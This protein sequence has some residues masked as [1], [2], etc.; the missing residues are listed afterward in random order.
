MG[1]DGAASAVEQAS[2]T[3]TARPALKLTDT[4]WVASSED[5]ARRVA[6]ELAVNIP[7]PKGGNFNGVYWENAVGMPRGQIESVLQYNAMCQWVRALADGRQ[8]D[9]AR[10][11]LGVVPQWPNFGEPS[12][13]RA[14]VIGL[15]GNGPM[16]WDRV[17]EC[18]NSATLEA[19]H[20]RE[21]GLL[22]SV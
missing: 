9:S 4:S 16:Y 2:T 10:R 8:A 1:H 19:A 18:R 22:P 3:L 21:A 17:E 5:E 15:A 7:V 13:T 11:I 20:A 6:A 12:E 14:R